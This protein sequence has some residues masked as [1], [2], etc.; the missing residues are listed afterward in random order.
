MKITSIVLV[1]KDNIDLSLTTTHLFD[2]AQHHKS[3]VQMSFILHTKQNEAA[4]SYGEVTGF[5]ETVVTQN[6]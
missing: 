1:L 5:Y 6:H 4:L 2:R 3:P